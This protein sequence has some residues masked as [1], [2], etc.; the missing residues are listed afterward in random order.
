MD[1]EGRQGRRL[2]CHMVKRELGTLPVDSS[3]CG[4]KSCA[5]EFSSEMMFQGGY[6]CSGF[7]EDSGEMKLPF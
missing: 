7:I 5:C 3:S 1:G 2:Q 6:C 4:A